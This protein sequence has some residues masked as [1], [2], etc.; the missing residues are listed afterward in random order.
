MELLPIE[1]L[2]SIFQYLPFNDVCNVRLTSRTFGAV[3]QGHLI[4]EIYLLPITSSLERLR[5]I[6]ETPTLRPHITSL[7]FEADTIYNFHAYTHWYH[8]IPSDS[9]RERYRLAPPSFRIHSNLSESWLRATAR[10]T[11]IRDQHCRAPVGA[12]H[13]DTALDD[14]VS[15]SIEGLGCPYYKA[16]QDLAEDINSIY[17]DNAYTPILRDAIACLPALKNVSLSIQAGLRPRSAKYYS[18]FEKGLIIPICDERQ[19]PRQGEQQ[20]FGL[21]EALAAA[22]I[23]LETLEIA[24]VN[25]RVL[26]QDGHPERML[27]WGAQMAT[28]KRLTLGVSLGHLFDSYYRRTAAQICLPYLKSRGVLVELL[29][30]APLLRYLSVRFD[31]DDPYPVDLED[32]VGDIIWPHLREVEFAYVYAS[33]H[34]LEDFYGRHN[35]TLRLLKLTHVAL[36]GLQEDD[37]TFRRGQTGFWENWDGFCTVSEGLRARGLIFGWAVLD[38][39]AGWGVDLELWKN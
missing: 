7:F 2:H 23:K 21:L 31:W 24:Y 36:N 25:H 8:R 26:D 14:G 30:N 29:A 18:V 39:W 17:K 4:R 19:Q 22:G 6:S 3:G 27:L 37:D 13:M 11:A 34:M 12:P 1:L 32:I 38:D 35:S 5:Q 28:L 10:C 16:F 33:R 9:L 20:L 15:N